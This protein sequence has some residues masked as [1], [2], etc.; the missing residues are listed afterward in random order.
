MQPSYTF[1]D[2]TADVLFEAQAPNLNQLFEQCALALEDTQINLSQVEPLEAV[3]ITGENEKLDYLLF[4]FLDD[5]VYYKDAENLLFS[6][7]TIT[8]KKIGDLYTLSCRAKGEKINRDK[9]ELKVDV[10]AITMHLF[11]VKEVEQGFTARVLVDI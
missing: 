8:V 4:D 6:K 5:L 10:K 1:I 3:H 7:F 11:E 2:H 9:H